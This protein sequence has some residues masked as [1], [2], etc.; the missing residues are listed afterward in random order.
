MS[1]A[2]NVNQMVIVAAIDWPLTAMA[3]GE[4]PYASNQVLHV[5][6]G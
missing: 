4:K 2:A 5:P 3:L 6:L 1:T